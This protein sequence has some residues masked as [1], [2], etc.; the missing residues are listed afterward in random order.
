MADVS[1]FLD[2]SS[3]K[4]CSLGVLMDFQGSNHYDPTGA[5]ILDLIQTPKGTR[6][7]TATELMEDLKK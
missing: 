1:Y 3:T 7:T 2:Q 5:P 4:E 6:E